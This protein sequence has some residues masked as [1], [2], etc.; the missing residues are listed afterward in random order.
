MRC[1]TTQT[2]LIL[3][4][5]LGMNALHVPHVCEYLFNMQIIKVTHL[6][7]SH[8]TVVKVLKLKHAV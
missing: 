7:T 8:G 3:I 2:S 5:S 1:Y 4:K 6:N